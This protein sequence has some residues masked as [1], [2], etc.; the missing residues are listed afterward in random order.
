MAYFHCVVVVN[1]NITHLLG[2]NQC[3]KSIEPLNGYISIFWLNN[4][5]PYLVFCGVGVK[6]ALKVV[7][8]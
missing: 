2:G 5:D 8:Q 1:A 7:Y 4:I 6:G 3:A